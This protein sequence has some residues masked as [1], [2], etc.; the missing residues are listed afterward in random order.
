MPLNRI[1]TILEDLFDIPAV[2]VENTDDLELDWG[3]SAG[4][5][6]AFNNEVCAEFDLP[7]IPINLVTVQDYIDYINDKS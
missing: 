5:R 3:M 2:R 7:R 1:A 6:H 4:E